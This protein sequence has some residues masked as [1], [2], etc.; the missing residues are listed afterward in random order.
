MIFITPKKNLLFFPSPN[1][2]VHCFV[3]S[4]SLHP[5]YFPTYRYIHLCQLVSIEIDIS[6]QFTLHYI[7]IVYRIG[8]FLPLSKVYPY[9]LYHFYLYIFWISTLT[10]IDSQN[11]VLS[12]KLKICMDRDNKL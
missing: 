5:I 12:C 3:P 8:P 9:N 2:H 1:F 11:L 7:Y 6:S 4:P 10:P